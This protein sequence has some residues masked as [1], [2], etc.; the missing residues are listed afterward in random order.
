M[1]LRYRAKYYNE[2]TEKEAYGFF[3]AAD[4][5]IKRGTLLQPEQEKLE[6][7][8]HFFDNNLPIPDY[9]QK[10]KNRQAAKSATSWYKD[11]ANKFIDRMNE[12]ALLLK[13]YHVNIE[14]ISTK[15]IQG[16]KIYEDEFQVVII[17]YR[18][19]AKQ[20]K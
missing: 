7:L 12:M 19:V 16:K 8:M 2:D 20:V 9:Y 13:K 3:W 14:R 11:T 18:D 15:K 4:Y 17:P 10:E 5:L 1:F 6:K